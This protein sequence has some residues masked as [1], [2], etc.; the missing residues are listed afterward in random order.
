MS[1]R[2]A[3]QISADLFWQNMRCTMSEIFEADDFF[4]TGIRLVLVSNENRSECVALRVSEEQSRFI[5]SNERSLEEAA[6]NPDVARTFAIYADGQMVG[7][8]MFAFDENYSDSNDRYWLWRFMIDEKM[9]GMG[10]GSAALQEI[11]SY[12]RSQGATHIRLSTKPEN[13]RAIAM[14]EKAGFV[15]TG[16]MYDDEI[17]FI[18]MLS[19]DADRDADGYPEDFDSFSDEQENDLPTD[20][21]DIF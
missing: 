19:E 11:I 7:F 21:P 4:D 18:L 3:K 6:A 13:E 8:T 10:C 2:N 9:Q 16:E 1:R 20:Y 12:F 14:Y 15:E 17:G 5:A